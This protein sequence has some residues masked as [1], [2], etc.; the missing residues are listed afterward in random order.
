MCIL[1]VQVMT[2]LSWCLSIENS[3]KDAS[4]INIP[5]CLSLWPKKVNFFEFPN[6]KKVHLNRKPFVS[7]SALP[8][9]LIQYQQSLFY[10]CV[11][12]LK[13]IGCSG[14]LRDTNSDG[15]MCIG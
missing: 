3:N 15:F 11:S 1:L 7:S 12:E 2:V 10:P 5:S 4:R 14:R 6:A 8:D 9:S 13:S